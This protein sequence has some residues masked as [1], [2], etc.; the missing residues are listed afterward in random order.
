VDERQVKDALKASVTGLGM[1][2]SD[3]ER[4]HKDLQ[5]PLGQRQPSRR[6]GDGPNR[7]RRWVAVVAAVAVAAAVVGV[8]WGRRAQP[9]PRPA[10]GASLAD[11]ILGVWRGSAGLSL[12]FHADGTT[13]FFNLSEG[14]L[15][16]S[17]PLQPGPSQLIAQTAR[18]RVS[19][20]NL[21][22]SMQDPSARS[23][24]YTFT[25]SRPVKGQVELSPVSQIGPG[26][27]TDVLS[28]P[29]GMVRISPA[30]PAGLDLKVAADSSPTP[31]F[32]TNPLYGVWLLKGTGTVLAVDSTGA[33]VAVAY[34]VDHNGTIDGE[35]DDG[36]DL[37]VPAAGQVVMKSLTHSSCGD[38]TLTSVSAGDYSFTATVVTDPCN[39]FAGQT[40]LQWLRIQ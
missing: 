23:C 15:H 29:F 31:V 34:R 10:T 4:M 17:N 24:E 30:S 13:L 32:D 1:T 22:L 14:V 18:Y 12:V 5:G 39:R 40:S 2:S 37:T 11:E 28:S 36:G 20:D 9:P 26:C 8:L 16:P 6:L 35:A 7:R 25:A 33:R 19:G 21:V 27:V 3:V 38:T